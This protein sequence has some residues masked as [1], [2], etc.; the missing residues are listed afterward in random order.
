MDPATGASPAQ[1]QFQ[2]A[3]AEP[4][5]TTPS[6]GGGRLFVGDD[7]QIL[8]ITIATPPPPSPTATAVSSSA[9]VAATDRN[10]TF[11]A[12]VTP[13]PVGGTVGFADPNPI[14]GCGTVAVDPVTQQASCTTRFATPGHRNV[15]AVYSGDAFLSGSSSA[16][17]LQHVLNPP[18]ISKARLSASSFRAREGT[19]LKLT[20]SEPATVVVVIE[21]LGRAQTVKAHLSFTGQTGHDRFRL[22]L[23]RLKAGRYVMTVSAVDPVGISSG[24]STLRF[25]IRT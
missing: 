5:F 23:K 4:H 11:T 3:S 10:V 16:T 12:T 17:L 7:N 20:L 21:R 14:A 24:A 6:A 13:R 22:R 15:I 8:A 19:V 18:S 9:S 1:L 2:L 25:R